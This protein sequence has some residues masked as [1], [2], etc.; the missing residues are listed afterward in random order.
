MNFHEMT[1]D[2]VKTQ[3]ENLQAANS[4]LPGDIVVSGPVHSNPHNAGLHPA[5][6]IFRGTSP[7]LPYVLA[8]KAIDTDSKP[9]AGLWFQREAGVLEAL[10]SKQ[11]HAHTGLT[12]CLHLADANSGLLVTEW[13][14]GR[15]LRKH[16]YLN[17]FSQS[18]RNKGITAAGKWL[19]RLHDS[20]GRDTIVFDTSEF[21]QEIRNRISANSGDR[22]D[23]HLRYL[24]VLEAGVLKLAGEPNTASLQHG[25]FSPNNLVIANK[26]M[27]LRSFDFSNPQVAPVEIDIAHFLLNRTVRLEAGLKAGSGQ[28]LWQ[29]TPQWQAFSQGYFGEPDHPPGRWLTWHALRT[30]L[31]KAPF[32]SLFS[33]DMSRTLIDRFDRRRELHRVENLMAILAQDL[34]Q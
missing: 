6:R 16:F 15:N 10:H 24:D 33:K 31:S 29:Q 1:A 25:D 18:R 26:K 22:R 5:T 28:N 4:A 34:E 2:A 3:L 27:D 14:K 13:L 7:S 9:D 11:D 19:S 21:V 20:M 8:I 32:L 12:A 17:M 23:R 30:L